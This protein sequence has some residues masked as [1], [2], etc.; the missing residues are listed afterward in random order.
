VVATDHSGY[1][2][3]GFVGGYIDANKGNA[4]TTFTV[5]AASAGSETVA[6][7]YANGTASTMTL[8]IYVNG[9]K[10]KQI[11]LPATANW[12][13]WITETETVT[14]HS[15]SNTVAYK[16]D[17]TDSGNVNIDNVT[18]ATVAAPPAGTYEAESA[19]LAGGVVVASDHSGYTG[20]GFVGGYTDGNKGNANT[21]LTVSA[22]SAGSDTVAVRY[23]NAS[24]ATQTL[25]LYVNGA[26]IKQISLPGTANWDTWT[27]ETETVTLHAGS[28]TVAYKFDTTDSGNINLDNVKVTS[29]TTSP[30]PTPT[31]TPTTTPTPPPTGPV[32]TYEAETGFVSGGPSVATAT[33]GY[34]GTGYVSGFTGQ[35]ARVIINVNVSGAAAYT[36]ATRY[37]N[38]SG[39]AKTLSQY[40]NGVKRAQ[41][42][43]PAGSGWLTVSQA[44]TLRSGVNLVEYQ[45]DSGDSGTIAIDNVAVTSGVAMA[46]RGATLP[47]TEY[48]ASSTTTNGTVLAANRAYLT[49][50]SE[51]TGR[52]A[53]ELDNT[54]QYVQFTLTKPSNSIDIRYN[55]PDSADGTGI[56]A[57]ISLYANGAK[58]QDITLTSKYEWTYGGYPYDNNPG[59]GSA[60]HFFDETHV[61]TGNYAAGTVL[62]LQK[63]SNDTAAHYIID[64]IDTEHV[65]P[66]FTMPTGYVSITNYGATANGGGDDTAAINN[67]ISAAQSAGNGVWVPAGTFNITSRINISN[68][69]IRGAGEWYSLIQGANG[70]G[71]FF[72]TGSNVQIADLSIDNAVTYRND[73]G[74]NAGL[75]GN[76]GTG[77]LIYDVWMEHT[78]VGAWIDSG[79]NGLY[80]GGVRIRDQFAD[81][82]N[83][84]ANVT[85]TRI[86]QSE[87]RNTGDDALAMFSDGTA[88]TNS[89]FT[90]NTV[91]D[92]LL[93]NGVGIYGGAND[94]VAD[95]LISDTVTGSA[96]ITVS[97]RFGI[98]FSGAILVSRNTLT[99]T[100]GYEPNWATNLGAIWIYANT[101]NITTPVTI[102]YNTINDST[103]Q[104][105][106][107]SYGMQISNL[108][109]DHDTING[110]GTYGIDIY[111]VTGSMT[112]SYVTVTGAASGGLNNPGGYTI[113][114]GAGDT[115]W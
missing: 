76:F 77:S 62:K 79:T 93:A 55:L 12:D 82:V 44:L 15:G 108:V 98:P 111:G 81:G 75:E 48:V 58:V 104:A 49:I 89:A 2:G 19:A 83:L 57:P 31:P 94:T 54:G 45:Y 4:N 30:T 68:V 101:S 97:S 103:Y 84:H 21:T 52:R 66:A 74:F 67:A 10:L 1:T 22:A 42:S 23:A 71:G 46:T 37:T 59:E 43:F 36:V 65:D 113:V 20:S 5:S 6:V 41:V 56:T 69:A 53:V 70:L 9:A 114:R 88:V 17:T 87:I 39:S 90:F 100:S 32:G 99:R 80:A 25:S 96:G 40:L 86:D 8:S 78:K 91:A 26:K 73:G 92:P 105:V 29:V 14:L 102:S 109:L 18:V 51:A 3:S 107:L 33:S 28:N 60:H 110:A 112:A 24:G 95:N 50:P 7:R 64:V 115:G 16:F 35:H 72:A 47:Y 38:S 11:A 27:T 63:D 34:T 85:N 106:L 61:L 13:S